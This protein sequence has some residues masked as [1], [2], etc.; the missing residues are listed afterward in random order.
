MLD[1][2]L[3]QKMFNRVTHHSAFGMDD[4]DADIHMNSQ[5]SLSHFAPIFNSQPDFNVSIRRVL[6]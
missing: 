1:E 3:Y 6:N 2:W 5:I 4:A